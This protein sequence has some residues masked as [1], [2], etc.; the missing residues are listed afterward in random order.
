MK[1]VEDCTRTI[2][3]FGCCYDGNG[4]E[5]ESSSE[6]GP[7]IRIFECADPWGH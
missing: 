5:R 4:M 2:F 3:D 1:L 6:L 7:A